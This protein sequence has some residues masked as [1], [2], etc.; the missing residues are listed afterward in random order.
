MPRAHARIESR[1]SRRFIEV[2]AEASLLD[3]R[4]CAGP[5]DLFVPPI[6]S[7]ELAPNITPTSFG[8]PRI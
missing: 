7:L 3:P 1:R 5:R 4:E 8:Q 2:G 6:R